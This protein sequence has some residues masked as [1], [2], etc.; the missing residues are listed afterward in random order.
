VQAETDS[1]MTHPSSTFVHFIEAV[2]DIL[3]LFFRGALFC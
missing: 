2:T 3:R 1:R